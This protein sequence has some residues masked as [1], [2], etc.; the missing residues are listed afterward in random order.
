MYE[1]PDLKVAQAQPKT[2]FSKYAMEDGG[3][4]ARPGPEQNPEK[5]KKKKKKNKKKKDMLAASE[6]HN[7][8]ID[9]IKKDDT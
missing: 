7:P 1:G 9:N 3:S 8:N 2:N 6:N 5:K 4:A